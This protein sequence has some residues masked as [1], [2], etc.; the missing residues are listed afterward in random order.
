MD[1][2]PEHSS[3]VRVTEASTLALEVDE[4]LREMKSGYARF[5]SFYVGRW[6]LTSPS[7]EELAEAGFFYLQTRARVQCAFCQGVIGQW[8]PGDEPITKH[9]H[10]F[11]RCPFLME[12]NVGNTP[13]VED[14]MRGPNRKPSKDV[15]GNHHMI[16]RK[17]T[18]SASVLVSRFEQLGIRFHKGPEHKKYVTLCSRI[19]SFPP[20]WPS[21]IH[22][23]PTSMA[24][25][26]FFYYDVTHCRCFHCDVRLSDWKTDDEP[27]T[28]HQKWSP[29]CAYLRRKNHSSK[30]A[31]QLGKEET[32]TTVRAVTS[33]ASSS[34]LCK[35]C[36][37]N[38]VGVIFF[39]CAHLVCC[40]GCALLFETCPLCRVKIKGSSKAFL[41]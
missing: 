39:P 10:H 24:E 19:K 5:Q 26:G 18:E 11:P 9:Q 12:Y 4:F 13:L 41:S 8:E 20:N 28:E 30:V 17:P 14:P 38:D 36:Y 3:P 15:C 29:N 21:G 16:N 27:L 32:V 23:D 25:A 37:E 2:G 7:P 1:G 34:H 6:P 35:V 40:S 31:S 22:Q 33:Q